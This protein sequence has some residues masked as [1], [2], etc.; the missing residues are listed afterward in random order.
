MN[1]LSLKNSSGHPRRNRGGRFFEVRWQSAA[2]TALLGEDGVR[3]KWRRAA[4]AAA[5]QNDAGVRLRPALTA[6]VLN[7]MMLVVAAALGLAAEP[8]E[9]STTGSA[10]TIALASTPRTMAVFD[11]DWRFS[12]GDFPSAPMPAFD[13]SAWRPVNLP[14]DWSIEGPFGPEFASGTGYAPGG[15]GWYRKHFRLDASA[16]NKLVA[17]E[18]DGAY[19]HAEV[20]INGHFVGGRPYGYSSFE[21]ELMPHL[22]FDGEEN[23][24]AVRVDHSR[25]ADSRWY[26]GSGIYRH[27]RLRITNKQRLA[28]WGTFVTS[29][30]VSENSATLRIET[31]IENGS[32]A[33]AFFSLR[34]EITTPDGKGTWSRTTM[35]GIEP[36]TNYTMVQEFVLPHP[37]LW[38]LDKPQLWNLRSRLSVDTNQLDGTTIPFGIRSIRFDPDKGF[39]LNDA[40]LK[41]KGVC[42]HHDAG[43]LGAAVP[44]KVW[45]RRLRMLKELGVNAIRTSHNPPAP[46]FLDLCDRLGLLVKDEAFDEFAP[47]K[48]KWVTGRNNGLPSRFGYAED[49]EEWSVRDI[50]DMIRRDRNHPSI[51]LW[52]I[53]NEIDYANDPF[54]HPVLSDDYRPENPAAENL[55]KHARPLIAAVKALDT[56][57]PVTAALANVAMSDAV[58]L[59]EL[60]DVVGYNYQEQRYPS[61]HAKFPHRVIF[62]SENGHQFGNWTVVRDNEYV[63]GQF[64]WTGIDYLG[65]ANRWPNRGS[66]AGLLDLC[67]FK[68]PLAWF[69]QSLWSDQPMVYLCA[70]S[71]GGGGAR[72]RMRGEESWNWPSNATVTVRCY[73]ACAEVQ[74]TLNG[75]TV[76]TKRRADAVQ[77]E[78]TWSVP[79]EPGVLKAVGRESDKSVSEFELKTAGSASRIELLP[80]V[81]QLSADGR[82][83]CHIEFRLVDAQGVRVPDAANEVTFNLDGPAKLLGIENGDLNS[84][85]DCKDRKHKA[86][87]GRGL[88]I[89]QSERGSG[90]ITVTATSPALD[91]ASVVLSSR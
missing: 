57:R 14:H 73:T 23:V 27:V 66:G 72:G 4:L 58:G 10:E 45:E 35:R 17:V 12:K 42:V 6:T 29:T 53:G 51:I 60:L 18:F 19:D 84:P 78:L 21:C 64:L 16:A 69:R 9:T 47:A 41:L 67:G 26:T 85:D 68:K 25:F 7:L 30:N 89:L 77:G 62:G 43:C 24:V 39:F 31:L 65:E 63:A 34:S 91:S 52:S 11:R 55:V 5:V 59:G 50:S 49:F 8:N 86:Y 83:I 76:G 33:P 22:K 87:H 54:S 15:I 32:D 82:D 13:D 20:W 46:E 61:D 40:P 56:T 79:F 44:E 71:G 38:T 2:T 28:S 80:D 3:E 1:T 90:K 36:G 74:L 75:K 48:N 37:P 81:N 88:A 70:S